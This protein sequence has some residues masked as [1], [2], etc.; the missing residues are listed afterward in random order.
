M[1]KRSAIFLIGLLG[2]LFSSGCMKAYVKSVGGDKEQRFTKIFVAEKQIA[3]QATLDALKSFRLDISNRETGTIQTRWTDNTTQR[4]FV[5]S[6]G[7][8]GS[9]LKAQF[10]YKV[11][12]GDGFYNGVK[13]VRVIVQKEQVVQR[14][15]LE[16]WQHMESDA[17]EEN[18]LLYRIG[19]LIAIQTRLSEED[20]RRREA[21]MNTSNPAPEPVSEE[22]LDELEP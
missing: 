8:S 3:W 11:E 16:G 4:N 5:D 19:R 22:P 14:D 17:I 13:A 10:R 9:Y 6:F 18:T 1:A 7:K 15:L 2:A 20:Q 21:E 12:L